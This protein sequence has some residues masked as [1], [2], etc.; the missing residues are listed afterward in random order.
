MWVSKTMPAILHRKHW[1]EPYI[2][3]VAW[4]NQKLLSVKLLVTSKA[5]SR[6][7]DAI[8]CHHIFLPVCQSLNTSMM[9]LLTAWDLT[10]TISLSQCPWDTLWLDF[11]VPSS[12]VLS[13]SPPLNPFSSRHW[14][15]PSVVNWETMQNVEESSISLGGSLLSVAYHNWPKLGAKCLLHRWLCLHR[16]QRKNYK[17]NLIVI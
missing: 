1:L 16:M 14:T 8:K 11:L 7:M 15:L 2:N 5:S 10:I 4:I 12:T 17:N 3:P 6:A 9:F 13:L